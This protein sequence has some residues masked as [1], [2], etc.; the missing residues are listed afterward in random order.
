MQSLVLVF[1]GGGLGSVLRF[2][3][4]R[5]IQVPHGQH[6]PWGTFVAN[7]AACLV[8]GFVI[9]LADHKNMLT[10]AARMFWTVGFCGGFSTF[11]TFSHEALVLLQN[12]LNLTTALYIFLSLIL[13][14]GATYAGLFLGES[15]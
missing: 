8:L 6:F 2:A 10:P 14:L 13:C 3:L 11:S 7:V 9:G 12:G 5:W 1:L 4:G 15:I